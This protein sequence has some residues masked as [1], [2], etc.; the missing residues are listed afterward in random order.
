M[1]IVGITNG[2]IFDTIQ[3]ASSPVALWFASAVF[4]EY[5]RMLCSKI[6]AEISDALIL[7]PYY[8]EN[9]DLSDGVG[10]FHD[11]IIFKS[12]ETEEQLK[13]ALTQ[14]IDHTKSEMIELFLDPK[15]QDGGSGKTDNGFSERDI[16]NG[17]IFLQAYLYSEFVILSDENVQ[18][19]AVL[20]IS[21]AL[22]A[23]ELMRNFP[24]N[25]HGNPF[26]K[27]F[28]GRDA[29][30]NLYLKNCALLR[31]VTVKPNPLIDSDGNV[32]S[33][34]KIAG[35]SAS[36][37]ENPN[38]SDK[39]KKHYYYAVVSADGDG[40]GNYLKKIDD[41]HVKDFSKCCFDYVVE[42]AA[43]IHEFGGMPIYAGGDDMLFLAPVESTDGKKTIY[44]LCA[45][46]NDLFQRKLSENRELNAV[47]AIQDAPKPTISFGISIQFV[48][49]PLYEALAESRYLLDGIVKSSKTT[50]NSMA[51]CFQKHSGQTISLRISNPS[52]G[53]LEQYLTLGRTDVSSENQKEE[54]NE[55]NVIRQ[56]SQFSVVLEYL[57]KKATE[58]GSSVSR[59]SYLTAWRN[60]F[61]NPAQEGFIQY[62]NEL[63]G[64][65]YDDFLAMDM[66]KKKTIG[67]EIPEAILSCYEKYS[68]ARI[69]RYV[70]TLISILRLRKF[71]VEKAG[72]E[73]ISR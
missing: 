33:I 6:T 29:A 19:N 22:D 38:C 66:N 61:D 28:A 64:M 31:K 56:L 72:E 4:S 30:S 18:D 23:M 50:R 10:K 45:E 42:S 3:E 17:R 13:V 25:D 48:K 46:I 40:M 35:G 43:R 47:K 2:P 37:S 14:I 63:G 39:L 32:L 1:N 24:R 59:E 57:N 58:P 16:K 49:Y 52:E 36:T 53:R 8:D 15:F 68:D 9:S 5:T 69:E 70:Q 55:T 60:F 7:S 62:L 21:D 11:R 12:N 34:E 20:A 51:V 73:E 71:N 65:F 67:I 26:R 41:A 44:K 54:Q 27:L